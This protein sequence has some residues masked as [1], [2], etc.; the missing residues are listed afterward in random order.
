MAKESV[1]RRGSVWV[2]PSSC[3]P[4]FLM[5]N[6]TRRQPTRYRDV[7]LTLLPLR[8]EKLCQKNK[9]LRACYTET[10]RRRRNS[11]TRLLRDHMISRRL[12]LPN[13]DGIVLGA[14]HNALILQSYLGMAGLKT[15][16]PGTPTCSRWWFNNGSRCAAARGP[17]Q[18]TFLLPSSDHPDAMVS[19][20]EKLSDTARLCDRTLMSFC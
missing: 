3:T 9:F 11:K 10:Q 4:I 20:P 8:S 15:I 5:T 13:I 12:T 16:L 6:V 1:P 18:H 7:V 14:G 17:S 19:R 2:G